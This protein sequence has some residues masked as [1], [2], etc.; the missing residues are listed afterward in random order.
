[1]CNEWMI[2]F[3]VDDLFWYGYSIQNG[4]GRIMMDFRNSMEHNM[5]QL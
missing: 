3:Y 1:M 4:Y 2:C 5:A